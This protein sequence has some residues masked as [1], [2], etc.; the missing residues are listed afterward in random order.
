VGIV[1]QVNARYELLPRG[2]YT[3]E[4][5]EA[6]IAA[7]NNQPKVS[8]REYEMLVEIYQAQNAIGI[9]RAAR[10]DRFAP[11]TLAKAENLLA[12]SRQ[13]HDRKGDF[14]LCL[15]QAR[16]ATQTA[17][18]ARMISE[19]R[20]K[21]ESAARLEA[22]AA[23]ARQAQAVAEQNAQQARA[24]ATVA[25]AQV[26]NAQAQAQAQIEAERNARLRAE[27]DAN[28]A[29]ELA[30]KLQSEINSVQQPRAS[31]R[32][33]DRDEESERKA[34]R[35]K[36]LDK[37]NET[38][39]TTRDTSRGLVVVV[40]DSGFSGSQLRPHYFAETRKLA[41]LL[42]QYRNLRVEVEGHSDTSSSAPQAAARAQLVADML[43]S[44]GLN[45]HSTDHGDT[46][47]L[48]PNDSSRGRQENRRI[49]IVVSGDSI[50]SLALWDRTYPV[51]P[52]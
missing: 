5:P 22:D 12:Q 47:P 19:Q 44:S 14:S 6:L 40:P 52:R 39:L 37:L 3:W 20:E 15:Q 51:V 8:T 2:H 23:A 31:R 36:L 21:Q 17:E 13:I 49:E 34:L 11:E 29:R 45:T 43:R 18:D 35:A 42:A 32:D 16:E 38:S 24:N 9:A 1:E 48:G 28:A 30:A 25:Q 10:A 50:G 27:A 4:T 41:S 26:Q 7:A 33:R 46:R